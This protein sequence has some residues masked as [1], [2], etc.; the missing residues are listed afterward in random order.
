MAIYHRGNTSVIWSNDMEVDPFS[1]IGVGLAIGGLMV[2]HFHFRAALQE[3]IATLETQT[4]DICN[5]DKDIDKLEKDV[6]EITTKVDLFWGALE[7][8]LPGILLRGNPIDASS[9]TAKLLRR[10][11]DGEQLCAND[12][13]ELTELLEEEL[14]SP[15]H[16]AGEKI[17]IALMIATI[18]PR[19]VSVKC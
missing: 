14:K 2:E 12:M 5:I 3:R 16:N 11:N 13:G 10:Y 4:R 1:L 6:R 17:A 7:T 19:L 15:D 18:R 8:Q 9:K